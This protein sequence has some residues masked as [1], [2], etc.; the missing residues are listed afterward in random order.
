MDKLTNLGNRILDEILSLNMIDIIIILIIWLIIDFI[1]IAFRNY[2]SY[3]LGVFINS[4]YD[5]TVLKIKINNVITSY[6]ALVSK[7][8]ISKALYEV[9]KLELET[10]STNYDFTKHEEEYNRQINIVY[11]RGYL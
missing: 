1:H 6:G 11:E 5:K 8:E 7:E 10:N 3:K 2:W 4:K 9:R